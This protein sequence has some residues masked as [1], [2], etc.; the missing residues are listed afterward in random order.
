MRPSC[1]FPAP[2]APLNFTA[3]LAAS[4]PARTCM[5]PDISLCFS[6][7]L[8]ATFSRFGGVKAAYCNDNFLVIVSDGS[9]L[10]SPNLADVLN[11]PNGSAGA[12]SNAGIAGGCAVRTWQPRFSVFKIPLAYCW[13]ASGNQMDKFMATAPYDHISVRG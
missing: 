5:Q 3:L 8:N 7:S 9:T 2:P 12:A 1:A 11:P 13:V 4:L 10:H 6:S